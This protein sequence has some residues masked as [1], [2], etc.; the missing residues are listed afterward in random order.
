MNETTKRRLEWGTAI[1]LD[2]A[3]LITGIG[4]IIV[5]KTTALPDS[6]W[7][8]V[9]FFIAAVGLVGELIL[10]VARADQMSHH[11]TNLRPRQ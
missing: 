5:A 2:A 9:G 7:A 3:L 1:A 10:G 11:P 6:P 4:L 8:Y